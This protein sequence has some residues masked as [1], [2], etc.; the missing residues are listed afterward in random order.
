MARMNMPSIAPPNTHANTIEL[1][2][3]ELMVVSILAP[4]IGETRGYDRN[5]AGLA[6]P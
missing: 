2:A 3:I 6:I 4:F 1:I 5:P